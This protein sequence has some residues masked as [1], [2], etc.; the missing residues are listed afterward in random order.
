[1]VSLR[2]PPERSNNNI[3]LE[4][5][6]WSISAPF[7]SLL[8]FPGFFFSLQLQAV[9]FQGYHRAGKRSMGI[10][11]IKAL[12]SSLPFLK[13]NYFSEVNAP[14]IYS[15]HFV[16]FCNP[17]ILHSDILFFQFSHCFYRREN[18]G[19]SLFH[20]FSC[21]LSLWSSAHIF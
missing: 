18:S 11:Q 9:G 2:E 13:I 12:Q 7:C 3:S 4:R 21:L 17:E 10:G 16:N 6:L 8:W 20:H 5:R 14:Q 15:K 1:M 19:R